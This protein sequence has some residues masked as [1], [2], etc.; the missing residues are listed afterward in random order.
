MAQTKN[1]TE[2]QGN[3]GQAVAEAPNAIWLKGIPIGLFIA[4]SAGLL[5]LA[6]IQQTTSQGSA[7]DRQATNLELGLPRDYPVEVVPLYPGVEVLETERTDTQSSEGEPMDRW[8][9][10]AQIDSGRKAIFDYYHG[11]MLEM[12]MAQTLF[13]SVPA[14]D[15]SGASFAAN[16]ANEQ[17]IVEFNIEKKGSDAITQLEITVS[18]LR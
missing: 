12:G 2:A 17:L 16:Y 18:R 3:N 13:I 1:Q 14:T 7:A 10:H 8:Y 9:I 6:N 11:L 15:G 5:Y 4:I